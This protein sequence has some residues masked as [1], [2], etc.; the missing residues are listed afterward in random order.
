MILQSSWDLLQPMNTAV[1]PLNIS[2]G[3]RMSL[4]IKYLSAAQYLISRGE[5]APACDLRNVDDVYIFLATILFGVL[6]WANIG[7]LFKAVIG[8]R[9]AAF[10]LAKVNE[11][12]KYKSGKDKSSY[13]HVASQQ[14]Q[15]K[16]VCSMWRAL[17]YVSL[18]AAGFYCLVAQPDLL[19]FDLLFQDF[20]NKNM[21][22]MRKGPCVRH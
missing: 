3:W 6:L 2:R 22:Y 16:F 17:V 1:N 20:P 9:V 12:G 21:R 14:L 15:L 7:Y 19:D 13:G 8:P 10:C 4:L 11:Q 5:D 18:L